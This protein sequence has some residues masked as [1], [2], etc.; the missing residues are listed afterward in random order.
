[1]YETSKEYRA[2]L[3]KGWLDTD[4]RG[5][6]TLSNGVKIPFEEKD[7]VPGTLTYT[8]KA[9]NGNDFCFGGIYVGELTVD[10]MKQVDRYSLHIFTEL[11]MESLMKFPSVFFMCMRQAEQKESYP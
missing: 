7:I 5:T 10:L 6:I 8:N 3:D 1:M 11:P 9:L 4:V 2:S